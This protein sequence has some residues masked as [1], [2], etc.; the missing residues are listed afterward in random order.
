MYILFL[1]KSQYLYFY[2]KMMFLI[3]HK[4]FFSCDTGYISLHSTYLALAEL[5]W[6]VFQS[7]PGGS[8]HTPDQV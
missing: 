1:E 6:S 5:R 7:E 3:F 2:E 4:N 8:V